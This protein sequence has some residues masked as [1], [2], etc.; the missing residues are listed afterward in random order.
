M[1]LNRQA[2]NYRS[3]VL[4]HEV[5]RTSRPY[6]AMQNLTAQISVRAPRSQGPGTLA[7]HR[8]RFPRRR[9]PRGDGTRGPRTS[10]CTGA[11]CTTSSCLT[12]GPAIT[13][14][15]V[16]GSFGFAWLT[17]AML[18]VGLVGAVTVLFL[19]GM[20]PVA[21]SNTTA[22]VVLLATTLPMPHMCP[23]HIA[24]L[25]NTTMAFDATL[26]Y[27]GEGPPTPVPMECDELLPSEAEELELERQLAILKA[28]GCKGVKASEYTGSNLNK[29][30]VQLRVRPPRDPDAAEIKMNQHCNATL[31]S[32]LKVALKLKERVAAIVGE[33]AV[34]AAEE[35]VAH[36]GSAGPSA[37]APPPPMTPEELEWLANWQDEQVHPELVTMDMLQA[38]LSARRGSDAYTVLQ[39]VPL[40]EAR[41]RAAELRA[42][43][44][45]AAVATVRAALDEKH[46]KKRQRTQVGLA[47]HVRIVLA[48]WRCSVML[49]YVIACPWSRLPLV[50]LA[51]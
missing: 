42:E 32:K 43:K 1:I 40:L 16:C 36:G 46:A 27:P 4:V 28:C 31:D 49:C 13:S 18:T 14:T 15:A 48:V 29:M 3:S 45:V 7:M 8:R 51:P 20:D 6:R 22:T 24:T 41:L 2:A 12:S 34:C 17:L 37:G 38:A 11:A 35:Q 21:T 5:H 25:W 26:G 10:S 23:A 44:A 47:C 30:G 33:A 39:E 50:S 19:A 9:R